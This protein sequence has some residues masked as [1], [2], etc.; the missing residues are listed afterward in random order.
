MCKEENK[1]I[2]VTQDFNEQNSKLVDDGDVERVDK[3][4]PNQEYEKK[5]KRWFGEKNKML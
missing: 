2:S 3:S 4:I 1:D 5:T